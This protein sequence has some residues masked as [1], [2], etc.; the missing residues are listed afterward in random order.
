MVFFACRPVRNF[1]VLALEPRGYD[2]ETK[3]MIYKINTKRGDSW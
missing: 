3:K 2:T 1:K